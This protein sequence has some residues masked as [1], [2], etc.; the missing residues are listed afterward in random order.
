MNK[1]IVGIFILMMLIGISFLPCL[2]SFESSFSD[3]IIVPDDYLSIQDAIDHAGDGD[4]V[5]VRSGIYYENLFVDKTIYLIG[6]DRNTTIIDGRNLS[7][8]I[9]ISA[10]MVNISSFTIQNGTWG[11]TLGIKL[12]NIISSSNTI[13][14]NNIF[15]NFF[16]GI[17]IE[18][19]RNN[20]ILKNN[21]TGNFDGIWLYNT[22]NNTISNNMAYENVYGISLN[23]CNNHTITNNIL[24][25]NSHGGIVV[26]DAFNNIIA[27]NTMNS[28]QNIGMNL[29]NSNQNIVK[30]NEISQNHDNGLVI[31]NSSQ[32]TIENNTIKFNQ[33]GIH[34]LSS[35]NNMIE[36]SIVAN[37][38]DSKYFNKPGN[39]DFLNSEIIPNE[40]LDV[41]HGESN[42]NT[43]TSNLITSNVYDGIGLA[44]YSNNN[45]IA[46]N[47]ISKNMWGIYLTFSSNNTI[48][49]NTITS[50][51][52]AGI[53]V[54]DW[55]NNNLVTG[56]NFSSN[57]TNHGHGHIVILHSSLNTIK[58]NNFIN[59]LGRQ[60]SFGYYSSED[61]KCNYWNENYW[62]RPRIF[63][64]PIFGFILFETKIGSILI[65]WIQFDWYPAKEPFNMLKTLDIMVSKSPI[66]QGETLTV[67]VLSEEAKVED[68][69]VTFGA[70]T[71][72]TD[73]NGEVDFTVPD[74]GVESAIYYIK[75]E[76]DGYITTTT[77][78]TVLKIPEISF[79]FL[80]KI[81]NQIITIN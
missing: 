39:K 68:V 81:L 62:N 65:P 17:V 53:R 26:N 73:A 16:N 77:S 63:P 37:H 9:Y 28:G 48:T 58:H 50:N 80:N 1:K 47:L 56:N 67:T 23:F 64:K 76:K 18:F 69:I 33:N 20:T 29:V 25:K 61:N 49:G 41:D 13:Y 22:S 31:V 71:A 32:N 5:Y 60:A 7:D 42:N 75:A 51:N 30:D 55:S 10:D 19:S 46:D 54:T 8:V 74:P 78:V 14:N 6:E 52:N 66:Y 21:I 40:L 59:K 44:H 4:T 36:N 12:E 57:F 34:I 35:Y 38:S 43:I 45:Y 27:G 2:K 24:T 79:P 11:I 72:M 70:Q 15:F 3:T